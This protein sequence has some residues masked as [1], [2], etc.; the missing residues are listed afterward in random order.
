M[1]EVWKDIKGYENLYEISNFGNVRNKNKQ[2]KKQYDNKGYLCVE[3]FKKNKRKHFRIHRLVMMA[4][5]DNS[6]HKLDINHIDGNKYNNKIDNLEWCTRKENLKHAVRTGLNKQS[7][8][9]VAEKNNKIIKCYSIA[10]SYNQIKKI[11]NINCKEK[12]FKENVRRALN[13]NGEYYGYH[14]KRGW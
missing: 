5:N 14:F 1:K 4:F 13:T 8:K 11:E 9:I 12:T 10:D 6:D 7:I 2:I 3:L